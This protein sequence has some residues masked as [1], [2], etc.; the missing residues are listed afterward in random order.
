[1][2]VAVHFRTDSFTRDAD[3]KI[4]FKDDG[5]IRALLKVMNDFT[6]ESGMRLNLTKTKAVTF[7]YSHPRVI[8]PPDCLSLGMKVDMVDNLKLLRVRVIRPQTERIRGR[9]WQTRPL[10]ILATTPPPGTGNQ[11]QSSSYC[12]CWLC[13]QHHR[14]WT[15]Y[16]IT[17][18][19]QNAVVQVRSSSKACYKSMFGYSP[20]CFR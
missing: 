19:F 10:C 2:A 5:R 6:K 8:F 11:L 9:C 20:T 1:M 17:N 15:A 4:N 14:I 12:L 13:S 3:G 7:N 16:S 18:D